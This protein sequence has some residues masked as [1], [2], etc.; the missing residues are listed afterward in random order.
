MLIYPPVFNNVCVLYS[1][2]SDNILYLV[3]FTYKLAKHKMAPKMLKMKAQCMF[4]GRFLID[5]FFLVSLGRNYL[6]LTFKS[7]IFAVFNVFSVTI[8]ILLSMLTR[9]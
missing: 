3:T 8:S 5:I 1:N 6:Y 4:F 2:L 9:I 7:N